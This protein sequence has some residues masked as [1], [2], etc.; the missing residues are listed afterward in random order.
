M[1]RIICLGFILLFS[2]SL[3]TY[4]DTSFIHRKDVQAFIKK[5]VKEHHFNPRQLTD[6]M[7]QVHLQP[8]LIESMEKPYEKKPGMYIRIYF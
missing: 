8:Q 2:F 1:Q 3:S 4:A 6:T 7:N 5:M